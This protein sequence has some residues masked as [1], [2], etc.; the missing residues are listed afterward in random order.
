MSF[1]AFIL[2]VLCYFNLFCRY[3]SK[4]DAKKRKKFEVVDQKVWDCSCLSKPTK[5][6]F[7][8]AW[9]SPCLW[10]HGRA[11]STQKK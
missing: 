4:Y 3:L 5:K 7:Q 9:H 11:T 10:R 6:K 8:Q 1:I 2:F